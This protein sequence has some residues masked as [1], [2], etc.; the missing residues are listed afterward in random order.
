ML[1]NVGHYSFRGADTVLRQKIPWFLFPQ[2]HVW[3]AAQK[4][5]AI[6]NSVEEVLQ[7]Q[8]VCDHSH[9]HEAW[10]VTPMTLFYVPIGQM[11]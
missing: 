9:E 6:W 8:R 7:L 4:M 1:P 5:T 2:L 3:V 10:G 11:P